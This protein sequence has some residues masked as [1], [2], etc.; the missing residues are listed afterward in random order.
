[1]CGDEGIVG[2]VESPDRLADLGVGD[3][4]SPL[5]LE[6]TLRLVAQPHHVAD[7]LQVVLVARHECLQEVAMAIQDGPVGAV[8]EPAGVDSPHFGDDGGRRLGLAKPLVDVAAHVAGDLSAEHAPHR[9]AEGCGVHP[10]DG[11]HVERRPIGAAPHG[12]AGPDD[13]LGVVEEEPVRPHHGAGNEAGIHPF[14]QFL[15]FAGPLLVALEDEDVGDNVGS[16]LVVE[17][18][19]GE[20]DGAGEARPLR[21]PPPGLGARLVEGEST[22]YEGD[23]ATRP[24][25]LDGAAD[26]PVMDGHAVDG[27]GLA[28]GHVADGSRERTL[29]DKAVLHGGVDDDLVGKERLCDF[30]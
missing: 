20:A 11:R 22:R 27:H 23:K 18:A 10:G 24:H 21:N 12:E 2:G 19:G 25:G 9:L 7:P 5:K 15:A 13:E 3:I 30:R 26:E 17:G 1:V 16:R 29:G 4:G 6:E 14:W 28:E 8:E